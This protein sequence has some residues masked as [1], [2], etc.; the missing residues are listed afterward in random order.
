M[1][2]GSQSPD[3]LGNLGEFWSRTLRH[4]CLQ[5]HDQY[6]TSGDEVQ[7]TVDASLRIDQTP[8]NS[9]QCDVIMY[10]VSYKTNTMW[11]CSC[12]KSAWGSGRWPVRNLASVVLIWFYRALCPW[13]G[14]PGR[15]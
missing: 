11:V 8:K 15:V 3:K 5:G 7:P 4:S 1:K 10:L 13:R 2:Q 12:F 6:F 9:A 14:I